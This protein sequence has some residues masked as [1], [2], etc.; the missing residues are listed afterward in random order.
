[1]EL[2][3]V[4]IFDMRV[5]KSMLIY[6]ITIHINSLPRVGYGQIGIPYT[7]SGTQ[8]YTMSGQVTGAGRGGGGDRSIRSN[9]ISDLMMAFGTKGFW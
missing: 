9:T 4:E 7:K 2:T 3:Y 6:S 1:M 8:H 5:F